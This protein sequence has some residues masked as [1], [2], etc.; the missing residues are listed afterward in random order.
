MRHRIQQPKQSIKFTRFTQLYVNGF[1]TFD[2]PMTSLQLL[3]WIVT[4]RNS[5]DMYYVFLS[6]RS[7]HTEPEICH[8][9][10]CLHLKI[11][12]P[13]YKRSAGWQQL[14]IKIQVPLHYF[15]NPWWCQQLR[16]NLVTTHTCQVSGAL[17]SMFPNCQFY[18]PR[19]HNSLQ[20][21]PFSIYN[22]IIA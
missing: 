9:S 4:I 11:S 19:K 7:G 15:S 17:N 1:K 12:F 16:W 13:C 8:V 20:Q 2:V 22:I 3:R 18:V 6:T 14:S 5:E 10:S 21:F